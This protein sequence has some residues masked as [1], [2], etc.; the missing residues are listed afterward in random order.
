MFDDSAIEVFRAELMRRLSSLE[1]LNPDISAAE[2]DRLMELAGCVG[3]SFFPDVAAQAE[4]LMGLYLSCDVKNAG[5]NVMQEYFSELERSAGLLRESGEIHSLPESIAGKRS[6]STALVP[7]E[8]SDALDFCKIVNRSQVP[9][10]LIKAADAF[11]RRNE[12]VNTVFEHVLRVMWTISP[13][14]SDEWAVSLFEK[15]DGNMDPDVARDVISVALS[16]NSDVS[17]DFFDWIIEYASDVNLLEYWPIVTRNADRLLCRQTLRRYFSRN[18]PKNSTLKWLELMQRSNMMTDEKLLGWVKTAL[19]GI[20]TSV[21]Q[22]MSVAKSQAGDKW[23]SL[24]LSREIAHIADLYVP[25]MLT[26]DQILALP[27][28]TS[29]LAMAFMGLA[30]NSLKEWE[31]ALSRFSVRAVTRKIMMD[32]KNRRPVVD[33]IRLLTFGDASAFRAAYGE[34]DLATEKFDSMRQRDKVVA[35]LAVYYGSFRRQALLGVEVAGRYRNL[36]RM[37]HDDFLGQYLDTFQL[38]AI[39]DCGILQEISSIA[40]AA[41]K[42]LAKRKADENSLEQMIAAKI[43]FERFVREKRLKLMRELTVLPD[44]Q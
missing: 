12:I 5:R 29:R 1:D 36:M 10:P 32:M 8:R 20:G 40:S 42:Y 41:R 27:D 30:G 15:Y 14:K 19:D 35:L 16:F 13:E 23:K 38:G 31:E 11:R 25:I 43:N 34:L 24:A 2:H 9:K 3:V 4:K 18:K 21:Q 39:H 7:F 28:G 6:F 17:K 37:I 22:F 33:T 44:K 26:A